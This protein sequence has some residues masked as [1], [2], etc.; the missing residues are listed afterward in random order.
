MLMSRILANS[1]EGYPNLTKKEKQVKL[2][3]NKKFLQKSEIRYFREY[4]NQ[5]SLLR[6][7]T[8]QSGS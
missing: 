3:K 6:R 4:S 5:I 7:I 8:I 2:L 1:K